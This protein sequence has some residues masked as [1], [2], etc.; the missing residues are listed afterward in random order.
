MTGFAWTTC[1]LGALSFLSVLLQLNWL[2]KK[3]EIQ[4]L[5][6]LPLLSFTAIALR[7]EKTGRARWA[8]PFHLLT[9]L[10]LI[11]ALDCIAGYGPTLSMMDIGPKIS[12]CLD[13]DRQKFF[14]FALNG[15]LF[16]ILMLVTERSKSLDLRRGSRVLE[17]F[18]I[19]HLL[20]PLYANAQ[21]HKTN[22]KVVVDVGVYIAFV[23][24][25]LALGPW[26]SRWRLLLGGLGGVAL[27]SYLL[28][29]LALVPKKAFVFGLGATGLLAALAAYLYL[30]LVPRPKD[31]LRE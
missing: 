14:S 13:A 21:D 18:A 19:L 20:G 24:L 6:T 11:G 28:I 9:L 15:V 22:P 27:G 10:V 8:L 26:R 3:P 5:W 1:L 29:D 23:V 31:S 16:L 4:A 7:F 12:P 2:G 25:L 30:R 17:I